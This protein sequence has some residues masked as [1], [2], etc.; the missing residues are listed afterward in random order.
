MP[1]VELENLL[2]KLDGLL[3]AVTG[4]VALG[5]VEGIA[6][7]DAVLLCI[8]LLECLFENESVLEILVGVAITCTRAA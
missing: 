5:R 2:V 7:V 3:V 1:V 4:I 8:G 6:V